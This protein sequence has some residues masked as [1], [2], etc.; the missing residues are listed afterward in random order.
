MIL[1]LINRCNT[2]EPDDTWFLLELKSDKVD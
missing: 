2:E 1:V